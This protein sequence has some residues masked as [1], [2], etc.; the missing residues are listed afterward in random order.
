MCDAAV[1]K[2]AD[3]SAG[4]RETPGPAAASP[5]PRSRPRAAAVVLAAGAASR[6]GGPKQRLLLPHVLARLAQAGIDDVVVVQGAHRLDAGGGAGARIVDAPDW[7]RGPGASLRAG[8]AALAPDV[9]VAIVC[10]ADG[11]LI[12]PAAIGRVLDAAADNH[13]PVAAA[14]YRGARGHP[15]VLAREA[16]GAVPDEGLRELPALL[17]PCDDLGSP[18]DVDTPDDLRALGLSDEDSAAPAR[19]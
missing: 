6:F 15:L 18:G 9:E 7:R 14:G 17:V 4:A 13:A 8:L 11:P 12:A 10:L 16:W 5:P 2:Q 1:P 3:P 19:T